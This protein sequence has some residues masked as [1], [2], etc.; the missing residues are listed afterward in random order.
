MFKGILWLAQI[1]DFCLSSGLTCEKRLKSSDYEEEVGK[2]ISP[3]EI[4]LRLEQ[5]PAFLEYP[6]E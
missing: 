2:I 6:E 4:W 3:S 1:C 5:S